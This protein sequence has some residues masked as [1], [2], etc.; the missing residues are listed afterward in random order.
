MSR[1]LRSTLPLVALCAAAA[2]LLAAPAAYAGK[3]AVSDTQP[4]WASTTN[5][6]GADQS[7]DKVV[8][9]VWLGWKRAGE[10][11][12]TLAG[13]Y[14]QSSP[15]Y[16][17]WLTPAQFHARFSPG[18]SEVA[19]VRSWLSSEGFSIVGVPANRLFVTAE[20]SVGEVE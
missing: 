16:H 5:M 12:R 11:D 1:R 8:F 2:C 3:V 10:L 14:D 7:S 13:L 15:S 17:R 19:A 18:A 9:S 20:G 6:T 4:D